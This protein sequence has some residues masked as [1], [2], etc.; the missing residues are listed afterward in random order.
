MILL[1]LYIL[2]TLLSN[3]LKNTKKYSFDVDPKDAA[4]YS[5]ILRNKVKLLVRDVLAIRG[6]NYFFNWR[7]FLK[8]FETMYWKE[9]FNVELSAWLW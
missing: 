6:T 2:Q 7:L 4:E 5:E 3:F 8:I 1:I 9:N